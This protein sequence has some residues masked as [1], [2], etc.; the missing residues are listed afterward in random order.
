MNE[1][2]FRQILKEA[3]VEQ[4]ERLDRRITDESFKIITHLTN[5]FDTR[6]QAEIQPLRE[7][8]SAIYNI[9]DGIVSRVKT[10]SEERAAIVIDQDRHKIWI[11]QLADHSNIKLVPEL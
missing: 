6:L 10:D 8:I 9:L 3:L 4:G 7:S 2:Q 5:N 1:K 11:T